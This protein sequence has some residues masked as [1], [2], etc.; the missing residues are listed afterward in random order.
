MVTLEQHITSISRSHSF[1]LK[2]TN[3]PWET[4]FLSL[5]LFQ[6]D[7][8]KLNIDANKKCYLKGVESRSIT[9]FFCS[10]SSVVIQECVFLAQELWNAQHWLIDWF[11]SRP[12][13]TRVQTGGLPPDRDQPRGPRR[14][15]RG[16]SVR[17]EDREN[18]RWDASESENP[19]APA[20]DGSRS[21]KCCHRHG[22]DREGEQQ[23]QD[24]RSL[25]PAWMKTSVKQRGEA[26]S[27]LAQLPTVLLLMQNSGEQ[28]LRA[29]ESK[30]LQMCMKIHSWISHTHI[31]THAEPHIKMFLF[32]IFWRT[33]F[34]RILVCSA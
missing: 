18:H 30:T 19:R 25:A 15:V 24:R 5:K 2:F 22:T 1:N 16:H 13:E 20:G 26:F 7:V 10:V 3:W 14:R 27:S 23:A 31:H 34:A 21:E 11:W 4:Q 8:W 6:T 33:Q 29:A 9:F 12:I 28:R 32:A 17:R